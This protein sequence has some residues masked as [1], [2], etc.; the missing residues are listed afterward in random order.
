MKP[1][2]PLHMA[3]PGTWTDMHGQ[4]IAVTVRLLAELAASYDPEV[5]RAPLV[6]GHPK[7]NAPAFGWLAAVTAEPAGLFGHPV[8]VDTAFAAAVRDGRYPHRSLSFW[9]A[10]HPGSPKPGQPYIRH[11]GMLGAAA[12]A[13]PGLQGADLAGAPDDLPTIA[14]SLPPLE[15]EMPSE[16][17]TVDLAARASAL[18]AREAQLAA[19]QADL[20]ARAK[21]LA[22]QEAAAR[23][24]ELVAF[25]DSLA[26]EARIRPGDVPALVQLLLD[27]EGAQSAICFAA[28]E[29][30]TA[31]APATGWFRGFLTQLPPLVELAEVATQR[32]AEAAAPV[33][34]ATPTGYA[35]DPLQLAH[36]RR[37]LAYQSAHPNTDYMTAVAAAS[38]V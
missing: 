17:D 24:A 22:D 10:D 3:R 20:A 4:R 12:P 32:R 15:P 6:V 25:A 2:P 1:I 37:A 27:L 36:H 34:F 5:F 11:L 28:P 8:Q 21:A 33:N 26:D 16:P 29:T 13:I 30:P 35:V 38:G 31:P 9:P 23:R 18:D 14:F 7:D 19:T